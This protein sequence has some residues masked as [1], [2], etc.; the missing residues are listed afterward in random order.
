MIWK[1]DLVG[2]PDRRNDE[3]NADEW[4][5]Q[6]RYLRQ[7]LDMPVVA[8]A[9]VTVRGDLTWEKASSVRITFENGLAFDIDLLSSIS[10]LDTRCLNRDS[11][12]HA[13]PSVF[14]PR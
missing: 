12:P 14:L 5:F 3:W 6:V 2:A 7:P 9:T 8:T 11:C 1:I 4:D 10:S 13:I